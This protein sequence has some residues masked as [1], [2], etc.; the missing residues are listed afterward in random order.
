MEPSDP[1]DSSSSNDKLFLIQN[2]S[3]S[4]G[5]RWEEG[6]LAY[7]EH[8]QRSSETTRFE[9][10][11]SPNVLPLPPSQQKTVGALSVIYSRCRQILAYQG[12]RQRGEVVQ[13][14]WHKRS[15]HALVAAFG[16]CSGTVGPLHVWDHCSSS[17]ESSSSDCEM[18]R[19]T[20][21]VHQ[22]THSSVPR[23]TQQAAREGQR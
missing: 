23:H 8:G 19:V 20:V 17:D 13:W 7:D 15:T 11:I 12:S 5:R 14:Q 1:S 18:Q 6:C 21:T 9:I 4:L 22:A 16:A 2:R 3:K 10:S